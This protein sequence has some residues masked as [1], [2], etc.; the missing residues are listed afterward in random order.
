[1]NPSDLYSDLLDALTNARSQ[2]IS[3]PWQAALDSGTSDQ[4]VVASNALIQV[5]SAIAALST[6]DLGDIAADMQA[7]EAGLSQATTN[8]NTALNDITKVQ[9]I[10]NAVGTLI[11]NVAKIVPLL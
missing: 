6:A 3:L 5:Q 2:M 10:L 1:L 9:N 11:S 4:R 8:L 7:N